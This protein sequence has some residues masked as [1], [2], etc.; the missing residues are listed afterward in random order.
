MLEN[1][2]RPPSRQAENDNVDGFQSQRKRQKGSRYAKEEAL[3][4]QRREAVE[5]RQRARA[6]REKDRRAMAKARKPGRDGKM[7]LG[8]QSNVL[9]DRVKRLVANG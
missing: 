3:A 9:L 4:E 8:R 5:E 7:K 1:R 2:G 6:S